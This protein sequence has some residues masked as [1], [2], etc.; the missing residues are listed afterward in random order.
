[1]NAISKLV[2][3]T[4]LLL[5]MACNKDQALPED[6]KDKDPVGDKY[7]VE[8]IESFLLDVAEPS[9]L[10]WALNHK[11][12]IVVDDRTNSAYII[13][14][15]GKELAKL[16][17]IGDDTEGVTVDNSKNQI[18]IA[19]E[20][21][22]K[23]I[24]LDAAGNTLHSYKIDINRGSKK[25]GLE[26]LAFNSSKNIFYILNEGEPGLL[27][28]WQLNGGIISQKKLQFAQDYSGIFF[29]NADQSL[30]IVSDKS[31]KLFYC[32]LDANVKQSFDLDYQKAEGIVVDIANNR[33]YIVSDSEQRLYTYKIEKL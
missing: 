1:M 20:A 26:G 18:W 3:L 28:K 15:K 24:Q 10:S 27:I 23:L 33:L 17:Y 2:L 22:S 7:K 4:F 9:G 30:W 31:K 25:K 12:L 6:G 29:D 16:P 32:D 5:V 19:E 14:V 11:D 8:F 13:D 21:E